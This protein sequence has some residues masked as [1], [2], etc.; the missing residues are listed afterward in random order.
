MTVS[1][2]S[3]DKTG[4]RD[5]TCSALNETGEGYF[6]TREGWEDTHLSATYD[7]EQWRKA[8][9][10]FFNLDSFEWTSRHDPV[11]CS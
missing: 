3:A 6:P 7:R 4:K 9:H 1:P 2:E 10:R 11:T 5:I 8:V